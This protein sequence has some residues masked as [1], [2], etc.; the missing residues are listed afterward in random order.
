MSV[1]RFYWWG[2]SPTS[3]RSDILSSSARLGLVRV[4][5][6][7]SSFPF[8][9]PR[10]GLFVK[11][12]P[13]ESSASFFPVYPTPPLCLQNFSPWSRT[14]SNTGPM[15]GFHY[16]PPFPPRI[17]PA[18]TPP[19]VRSS[20]LNLPHSPAAISKGMFVWSVFPFSACVFVGL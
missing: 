20:P 13:C 17:S 12:S 18:T 14:Q 3:S 6:P 4:W 8:F 1:I 16:M 5:F 15:A 19:V 2:F 11:P 7:Q 9:S 10:L